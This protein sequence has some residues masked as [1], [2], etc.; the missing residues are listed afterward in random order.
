MQVMISSSL[1]VVSGFQYLLRSEDSVV[2]IVTRLCTGCPRNNPVVSRCKRV[3]S[4]LEC[5]SGF[6]DQPSLLFNVH[7]GSFP[8]GVRKLRC[9]ADH[10]P[11]SSVKVKNVG[12]SLLAISW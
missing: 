1:Q 2:S 6:W 12:L 7:P 4:S 3:F 10:S 8:Q 5:S 9:E 11:P